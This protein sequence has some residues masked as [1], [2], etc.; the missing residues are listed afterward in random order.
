MR[1]LT[2]V[3][4][5]AAQRRMKNLH[6]IE[7][8]ESTRLSSGDRIYQSG[9]DPSG[10]AISTVMKAQIVGQN[11]AQRNINDGISLLQVA[12]GTLSNMHQMS[13]RLKELSIAA[14]NDTLADGERQLLQREFS[15]TAEEY[16]RQRQASMFN[17]KPILNSDGS[18]YDLQVGIHNKPSAD[19]ISYDMN[20]VLN[21]DLGLKRIDI[22]TKFGAR[23][24]IG[25]VD[26][27]TDEISRSRAELGSISNRMDSAL[28]NITISNENLQSANSKIRDTNI[29]ESVA[30]RAIASI[31]KDATTAT[32]VHVN[33]TPERVLKL[34]S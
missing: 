19:R 3:E 14:A 4:S 5:L 21:K 27:L 8:R 13:S 24:A 33:K 6:D 15:T 1:V 9:F 2:N 20:R 18:S 16:Q 12:E 25:L 17:G 28:Q 32:L 10:L 23:Q 31:N 22:G 26:Q 11:Q 7:S 29:A 30:T 34:L